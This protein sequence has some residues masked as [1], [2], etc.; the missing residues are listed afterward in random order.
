[1]TREEKSAYDKRYHQMHKKHILLNHQKR[2]QQRIATEPG[3]LQRRREKE[4]VWN[5]R[6]DVIA[7]HK[8]RHALN[9]RRVFNAYGGCI[10]ALCGETDMRALS[11]DH[12]YNDGAAHRRET[13]SGDGQYKWLK[14]HHY[15]MGFQVLCASCNIAK[16]LNGGVLPEIAVV[17]IAI[18]TTQKTFSAA[19]PRNRTH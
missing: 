1:M 15:P 16:H 11:L 17:F 3:F 7:A 18:N 14:A 10:C 6:P 13:G 8:K 9:K 2:H 4:R 19:R 5:A 12:I